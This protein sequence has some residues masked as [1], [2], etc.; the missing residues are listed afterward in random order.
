MGIKPSLVDTEVTVFMRHSPGDAWVGKLTKRDKVDST[1]KVWFYVE[2]SEAGVGKG[3]EMQ[4]GF[5]NAV[6]NFVEHQRIVLS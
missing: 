4:L 2:A 5:T 6:V 3:K 1:G